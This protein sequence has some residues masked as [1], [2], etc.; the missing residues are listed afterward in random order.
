MADRLFEEME[1]ARRLC[2]WQCI[3]EDESS[4]ASEHNRDDDQ[5]I[6]NTEGPES[7]HVCSSDC[8]FMQVMPGG[9]MSCSLTGATNRVT[10]SN[11][12][13][14]GI[15]FR[16][17]ENA[18]GVPL[19]GWRHKRDAFKA[20][21]LAYIASRAFKECE[22]SVPEE[23]QQKR[24]RVVECV[25]VVK[26]RQVKPGIA[27]LSTHTNCLSIH[28]QE[29]LKVDA[30][31]VFKEITKSPQKATTEKTP[32]CAGGVDD[33]KGTDGVVSCTQKVKSALKAYLRDVGSKN[34][35]PSLNTMHDICLLVRTTSESDPCV[36]N[37][38]KK[39]RCR[40]LENV[41]FQEAFGRLAVCMWSCLLQTPHFK[42]SRKKKNS[43][44]SFVCGM[45]YAFKRG[46]VLP[47]GSIIVPQSSIVASALEKSR[48]SPQF[49][50]T[51]KMHSFS[52]KGLACIHRCISSASD[53][54]ELFQCVHRAAEHLN[55]LL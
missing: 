55:D 22:Q 24:R 41:L 30:T 5:R 13:D 8:P 38:S 46:I 32:T 6:L 4:D 29:A 33:A 7:I 50:S 2:R 19:G 9:E 47:C 48:L 34:K 36:T 3:S 40:V 39:G 25:T 51:K 21:Q 26:E 23:I 49:E 42:Q 18:V 53:A 10:I 43:F 37:S 11:E 15:S 1:N 20:S 31:R 44:R 17:E 14:Y 54:S 28:Q 52:H 16:S 12:S 27:S 45:A 35:L